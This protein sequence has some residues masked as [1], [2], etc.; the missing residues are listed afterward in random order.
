GAL[1]FDPER[2]MKRLAFTSFVVQVATG[3]AIRREGFPGQIIGSDH[4]TLSSSEAGCKSR[5]DNYQNLSGPEQSWAPGG[6]ADAHR[7]SAF[8]LPFYGFAMNTAAAE[9]GK[10][11]F[12]SMSGACDMLGPRLCRRK[13]NP[14]R[15]RRRCGAFKNS[16][17]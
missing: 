2:W 9:P 14:I 1:W 16:S 6:P 3:F 13:A 5:A 4:D 17:A 11:D 15:V 12:R 7:V 10:S 8:L